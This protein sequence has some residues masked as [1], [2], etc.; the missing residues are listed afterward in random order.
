M[1]NKSLALDILENILTSTK[2][3]KLRAK[4]VKKK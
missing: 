1:Y 2:R 4:N 3:I